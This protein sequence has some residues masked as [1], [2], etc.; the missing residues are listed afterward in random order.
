MSLSFLT[1]GYEGSKKIKA[2]HEFLTVH[3]LSHVQLKCCS[4]FIEIQ[5]V[6]KNPWD[7]NSLLM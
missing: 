5:D 7:L 1:L 3:M 4:K 6:F 2:E